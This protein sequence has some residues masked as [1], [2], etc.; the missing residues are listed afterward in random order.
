[1]ADKTLVLTEDEAKA[2]KSFF[3]TMMPDEDSGIPI[4]ELLEDIDKKVKALQ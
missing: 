2:L 1:M 4:L 3:D